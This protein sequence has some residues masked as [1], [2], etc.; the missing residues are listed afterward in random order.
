MKSK[1]ILEEQFACLFVV[2]WCL[3]SFIVFYSHSSYD[4]V[5]GRQ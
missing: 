2:L 4:T 1:R 5:R 3:G